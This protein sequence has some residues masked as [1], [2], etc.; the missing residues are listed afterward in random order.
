MRGN[1]KERQYSADY[2]DLTKDSH[3]SIGIFA[4]WFEGTNVNVPDIENKDIVNFI[5]LKLVFTPG[6]L[7]LKNYVSTIDDSL[8]LFH[9]DYSFSIPVAILER[10]LPQWKIR[11]TFDL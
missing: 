1:K 3:K 11:L 2:V 6:Y 10:V 4:N 9:A 5:P 8:L 7:S